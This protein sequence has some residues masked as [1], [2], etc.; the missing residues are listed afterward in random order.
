[1]FGCV[2]IVFLLFF[3]LTPPASLFFLQLEMPKPSYRP[4][5]SLQSFRLRTRQNAFR[6]ATQGVI[7]SCFFVA[8]FS[9]MFALLSG[10]RTLIL[11]FFAD[12]D[13][14]GCQGLKSVVVGRFAR[15]RWLRG[16]RVLVRS[17][18]GSRSGLLWFA[19]CA[20]GHSAGEFTPDCV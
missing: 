15:L 19:R 5:T 20:R 13:Q 18:S 14:R 2:S 8:A 7:I 17:F 9:P 3:V 6:W 10:G 11:S 12:Q 16:T 4:L 1:M